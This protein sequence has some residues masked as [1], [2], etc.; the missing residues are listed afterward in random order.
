MGKEVKLVPLAD[1]II[2][3][4]QNPKN[5]QKNLLELIHEFRKVVGHEMNTQ[6]SCVS[7]PAM[8]NLKRKKQYHL[9]QHPKE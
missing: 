2:P 4:I 1:D 6:V 9:Q 7:V 5:L 8:T 3:Y